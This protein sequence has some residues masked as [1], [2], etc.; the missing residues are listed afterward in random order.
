[1]MSLILDSVISK[2]Q[3]IIT[4]VHRWRPRADFVFQV[5]P[6]KLQI[7]Q[8][9]EQVLEC[10]RLRHE[11]FCREMAGRQTRTGLDF[12]SYDLHCDHL[13]IIHEDTG[14]LVGTYRLNLSSVGHQFYTNSEFKIDHWIGAQ[15]EPFIELGRACI[16]RD[17]R[18]GIVMS[19]LWRGIAEYMKLTQA[20][21]LIGCSSVKVTDVRSAALIYKYFEQEGHTATEI[22]SVRS[23]YDMP[24]FVFWLM[25]FSP[26]LTPAQKVEAESKIPNLLSSYIKAGAR[27]ASY[28]AL[29]KDFNCIDFFTVLRRENLDSKLVRRFVA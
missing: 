5:G 20:Q 8:S 12:D 23:K 17:H 26:G 25:I 19:L 3:E 16:H 11:V 1:M 21:Q 28:P 15:T 6:Y 7:A 2:G 27:V 22:F 18:R 29:D 13:I 14:H 4:K 24:D 9:R 10:F